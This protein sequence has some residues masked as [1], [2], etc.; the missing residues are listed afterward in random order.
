MGGKNKSVLYTPIL[1]SSLCHVWKSVIKCSF[2]RNRLHSVTLS[3]KLCPFFL[4]CLQILPPRNF[5]ELFFKYFCARGAL[6]RSLLGAPQKVCSPEQHPSSFFSNEMSTG[7]SYTG[8]SV[9]VAWGSLTEEQ[10]GLERVLC[11]QR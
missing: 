3:R 7:P 4:L 5:R 9:P 6:P 2:H 8:C 11:G 10:G 1:S